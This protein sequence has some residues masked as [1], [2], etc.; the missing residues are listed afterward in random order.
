MIKDICKWIPGIFMVD[1]MESDSGLFIKDQTLAACRHARNRQYLCVYLVLISSIT[2]CV[3]RGWQVWK[4]IWMPVWLLKKGL[5][6]RPLLPSFHVL[7]L[8][9]MQQT[10]FSSKSHYIYVCLVYILTSLKI[11]S[12]EDCVFSCMIIAKTSHSATSWWSTAD[13][14][15]FSSVSLWS[16]TNICFCSNETSY[17]KTEKYF[18]CEF[19]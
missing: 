6:S 18:P 16:N 2:L 19:V 4:T 17:L 7:A 11:S 9:F 8:A 15:K 10:A 14:Q 3:H 12:V 13:I 5:T 1:N